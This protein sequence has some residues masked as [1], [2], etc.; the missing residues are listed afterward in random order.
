[1]L[2]SFVG[3]PEN[4]VETKQMNNNQKTDFRVE[5]KT[6]MIDVQIDYASDDSCQIRLWA[7]GEYQP[8][9]FLRACEKAL[10]EWDER[11]TS[12][13]GKAVL[14]QHWR[15]VQADAETRAYGVCDTV[16]VES[17]PGCGAYAVTV[18]ADWLPLHFH[19]EQV[20]GC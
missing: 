13:A 8:D 14:H 1:M 20:A 18:L 2:L 15:T 3:S 4:S 7:R 17:K 6:T 11:V 16:H 9:E 5:R 10:Q 12:L 19:T